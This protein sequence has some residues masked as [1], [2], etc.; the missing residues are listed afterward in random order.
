[1]SP[2]KKID[3]LFQIGRRIA[4][5]RAASDMTQERFAEKAGITPQYLQRVEAGN[6]N[7]TIRSLERFSVLLGVSIDDLFQMP[8][9]LSTRPGRPRNK[10]D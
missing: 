6:E 8:S 1:M 2:K 4:E 3:L 9:N 7:L 10:S 5:L